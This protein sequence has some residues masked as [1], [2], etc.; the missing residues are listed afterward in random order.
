MYTA[1][2]VTCCLLL[3]TYSRGHYA[4]CPGGYNMYREPNTSAMN[5]LASVVVVKSMLDFVKFA[6]ILI[7]LS[8]AVIPAVLECVRI[9]WG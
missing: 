3:V 2:A 4:H 9:I 5:Q 6:V 1:E 7:F 8:L